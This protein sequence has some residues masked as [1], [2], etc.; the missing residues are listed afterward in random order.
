[1]AQASLGI[2]N[3]AKTN[4][5]PRLL[6]AAEIAEL[7]GLSVKTV[8]RWIAQGELHAHQ[9]GRQVRVSEDDLLSFLARHR[10]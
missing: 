9:F 1:V 8:R 2:T 5:L 3:V 6:T 4:R 10:S 7:L